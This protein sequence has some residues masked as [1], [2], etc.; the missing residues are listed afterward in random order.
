[1]IVYDKDKRSLLRCKT[2]LDQN[3][4]KDILKSHGEYSLICLSHG[5]GAFCH[6]VG[7]II[8]NETLDYS[9]IENRTLDNIKEVAIKQQIVQEQYL[10]RLPVEQ[11]RDLKWIEVNYLHI[12]HKYYWL[13]KNP[14]E[15]PNDALQTLCW[16]C[17]EELHANSII[18]AYNSR[19][20]LFDN[21]E[22]C[23]RCYGAG[24]L[25][26]FFHVQ[27]GICFQCNGNRFVQI[28]K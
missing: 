27:A 24:Y 25:P 11:F 14:W 23:T 15:Y 9:G 5:D 12:H 18:P 16:K 3:H 7:L 4:F 21:Y 1:M 17:H 10:R 22:V 6:L 28:R 19:F 13:N 2:T 8:T 20:E 26:Q